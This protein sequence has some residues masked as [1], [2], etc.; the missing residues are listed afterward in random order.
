MEISMGVDSHGWATHIC[1]GIFCL[2][3]DHQKLACQIG[4]TAQGL[5]DIAVNNY[6][7]SSIL[8][9]TKVF[10]QLTMQLP[11]EREAVTSSAGSYPW[12]RII[13]AEDPSAKGQWCALF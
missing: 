4:K 8:S 3:L 5:G 11:F 6:Q 12:H 9:Q 10:H 2:M 7:Q 13:V 1:D